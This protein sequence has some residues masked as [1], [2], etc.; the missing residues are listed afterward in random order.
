MLMVRGVLGWLLLLSAAVTACS[1]P[2][3][4]TAVQPEDVQAAVELL[5]LTRPCSLASAHV[6]L[7]G[8]SISGRLVDAKG[9]SLD[10]CLD[11]RCDRVSSSDP[12]LART[13]DRYVLRKAQVLEADPY[14]VYLGAPYLTDAAAHPLAV[15]S[16]Q[17]SLF[18]QL[19]ADAIYR[20]VPRATLDSL[21][22]ACFDGDRRR[23]DF[24]TVVASLLPDQRKAFQALRALRA[25]E[26]QRSRLGNEPG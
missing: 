1:A 24:G 23:P 25:V 13:W 9:K 3:N 15:G 19:L 14:L 6:V 11:R 5:R 4:R 17:E 26:L 12:P 18:V 2:P 8:G 20:H 7:D 10:F 22:D 21:Y 16:P